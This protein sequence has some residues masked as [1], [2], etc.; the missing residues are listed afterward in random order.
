MSGSDQQ[1]RKFNNHE[2]ADK[3]HV[4]TW[5]AAYDPPAPG[6][7]S[8]HRSISF[9]GYTHE[10]A[11]GRSVEAGNPIKNVKMDVSEIPDGRVCDGC[12]I[13]YYRERLDEKDDLASTE[14]EREVDP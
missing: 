2:H 6:R 7:T 10:L 8:W 14:R 9:D 4:G 11:C 5:I 3:Y 12:K 1:R 13:F